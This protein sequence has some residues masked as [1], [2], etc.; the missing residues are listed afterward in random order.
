MCLA[1]QFLSHHGSSTEEEEKEEVMLFWNEGKKQKSIQ[2]LVF[3]RQ[4]E[5]QEILCY[6]RFRTDN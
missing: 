3:D 5:D 1:V 2:D 6:Y 4:P